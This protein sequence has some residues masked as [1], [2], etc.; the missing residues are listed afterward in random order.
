MTAAIQGTAA[1]TL[2]TNKR[3]LRVFLMYVLPPLIALAIVLVPTLS[4]VAVLPRLG[5]GPGYALIDQ[6][7]EIVSNESLRG[8][9]I[10]YG[11]A[12]LDCS[13]DCAASIA[14][15]QAVQ[16]EFPPSARSQ[17]DPSI[18][19]VLIVVDAIEDPDLLQKFGATQGIEDDRWSILSGNEAAIRAVVGSGF[20]VYLGRDDNG[21]VRY[22]PGVF[23][24]DQAG[25]LR[26]EY[27]NGVPAVNVI[28]EDIGR[29]IAEA[30]AGTVGG[31]FYNAAHSLSL[32]CGS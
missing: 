31:L 17:D 9:I 4:T 5:V 28:Q 29:V 27:R 12:S 14:A 23:L 16:S 8:D 19:F 11:L 7:G 6:R 21:Q 25:F 1:P 3:R 15:M 30:N 2:T 10:V 24:T 20:E 18:Q 13:D 22:D 26:A 32:T